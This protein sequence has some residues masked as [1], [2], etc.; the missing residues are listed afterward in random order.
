MHIRVALL[1]VTIQI[2]RIFKVLKIQ[3]F[4]FSVINFHPTIFKVVSVRR[5]RQRTKYLLQQSKHEVAV[6]FGVAIAKIKVIL[7]LK[8]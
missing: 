8:L 3:R 6:C 4:D 7:T 5:H 1:S 2:L